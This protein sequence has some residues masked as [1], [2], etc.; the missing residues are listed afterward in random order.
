[1]NAKSLI[2]RTA[3]CSSTLGDLHAPSL[4]QDFVGVAHFMSH[5]VR[6]VSRSNSLQFTILVSAVV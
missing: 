3:L 1:M 2:S 4:L 6:N 5:K